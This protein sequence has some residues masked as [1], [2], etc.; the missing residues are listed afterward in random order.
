MANTSDSENRRMILQET[1]PARA[2]GIKET[3]REA[4]NTINPITGKP[5]HDGPGFDNWMTPYLEAEMRLDSS[6]N[7][8]EDKKIYF[9]PI[10]KYNKIGKEIE[11]YKP[12]TNDFIDYQL[13]LVK[14]DVRDGK[15]L[16]HQ[17]FYQKGLIEELVGRMN[18]GDVPLGL[19]S[20]PEG[21]DNGL[22]EIEWERR[23]ELYKNNLELRSNKLIKKEYL[24]PEN[25]KEI[26]I[27]PINRLYK[28]NSLE[29]I[30]TMPKSKE[31]WK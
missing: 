10:N 1:N 3:P 6:R 18:E 29:E 20:N 23:R 22:G 31:R 14:M 27:G 16:A 26:E 11:S 8:S 5:Y 30:V 9:T 25:L 17:Y 4:T 12:T 2:G 24:F 19:I 7:Q 15:M 28:Y 21:L 13:A